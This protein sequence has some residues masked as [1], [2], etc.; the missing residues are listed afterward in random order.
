MKPWQVAWGFGVLVFLGEWLGGRASDFAVY[1]HAAQTWAAHP[2]DWAAVYV[3]QD[4]TPYKYHPATLFF[5]APFGLMP[6]AAARFCFALL[7]GLLAADT[8]RRWLQGSAVPRLFLLSIFFCVHALSWQFKFCNITVVML[9]LF[10]C[11]IH[12]PRVRTR[13]VCTALLIL[14][15]PFWLILLPVWALRRHWRV[16]AWTAAVCT[17][18]SALPAVVTPDITLAYRPW[19]AVLADPMNAHNFPKHDNQSWFAWAHRHAGASATWVAFGGNALFGAVWLA[20]IWRRRNAPGAHAL[21]LA[22]AALP[23]L[24]VGPLSWIHHGLLLLPLF[25]LLLSARISAAVLAVVWVCLNGTGELLATRPGF[26]WTHTWGI[27]LAGLV[28]LLGA[29]F[30]VDDKIGRQQTR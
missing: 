1:H 23:L 3:A 5:F 29:C 12:S 20:W 11:A 24:W 18:L 7:D 6:W 15:K 27:P 30:T 13:G 25:F 4:L 19:F 17:A 21:A 8:A 10:T 16:L 9:W 14:F 2:A 26:V 22:S 28:L